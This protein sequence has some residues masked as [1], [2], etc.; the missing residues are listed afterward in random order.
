MTLAFISSRKI[1]IGDF[2]SS[3]LLDG[4]SVD[5]SGEANANS[6]V[7]PYAGAL[8]KPCEPKTYDKAYRSGNQSRFLSRFHVLSSYD[9]NTGSVAHDLA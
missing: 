9:V 6:D 4:G 7:E 8:K 3:H 1:A 2:L 5:T